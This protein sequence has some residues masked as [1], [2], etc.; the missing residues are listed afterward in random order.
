M[1]APRRV[2]RITGTMISIARPPREDTRRAITEASVSF[3]HGPRTRG[4]A[5]N[6]GHLLRQRE[7]TGES[8]GIGCLPTQREARLPSERGRRSS[9]LEGRW[10]CGIRVWRAC[11][12]AT[13]LRSWPVSVG[14]LPDTGVRARLTFGRAVASLT[15]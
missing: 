11:G 4:H 14:E 1:M 7:Q 10:F 15:Y 6:M 8:G 3:G 5:I 2:A 12:E 13:G 9:D